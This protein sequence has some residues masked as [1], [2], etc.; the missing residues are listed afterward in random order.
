MKRLFSAIRDETAHFHFRIQ[1]ARLILGLFPPY[2]G[3]R[4]RRLIYRLAGFNIH[5]GTIFMGNPTFT[6]GGPI[7]SRLSIGEMCILN[8]GVLINLGANVMIGN[9]VA[10]GHEVIIMTESH[11]LGPSD[12]RAG[13]VTAQPV[14]ICDGAWIGARA[15]IQ[16]G[17]TI[18]KGAVV[19]AGA[20]V[21]R[22]VP[23]DTFVGG[24]P[25][26]IIKTLEN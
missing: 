8:I 3:V 23:P 17:V 6:G 21:S 22:D 25:A 10:I 12:E 26:S 16:P 4:L 24:V 14:N 7:E 19:A 2:T 9:R 15:I 13:K 1:I 5:Q 20:V 11:V 18:G